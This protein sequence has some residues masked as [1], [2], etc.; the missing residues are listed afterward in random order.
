MNEPLNA[1]GLTTAQIK[2][3]YEAGVPVEI[4]NIDGEWKKP[5]H[6]L[7][8]DSEVTRY[9]IRKNTQEE[10]AACL[11]ALIHGGVLEY[12]DYELSAW[13]FCSGTSGCDSRAPL[14]HRIKKE[15]AEPAPESDGLW[16]VFVE[17][18]DAPKVQHLTQQQARDEAERLGGLIEN[19]RRS[20]FLL[21][22]ED[23]M[24]PVETHKWSK[25][26]A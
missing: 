9:R 18:R 26:T 7:C 6:L 22:V 16:M 5:T 20:I 8:F 23:V 3:A 15:S 11:Q 2:A 13:C 1:Q 4:L 17:G 21:R 12:W 25:D 14:F 24:N 19:T 10:I